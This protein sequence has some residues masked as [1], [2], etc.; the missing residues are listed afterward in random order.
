[1]TKPL[2]TPRRDSPLP[3][4]YCSNLQLLEDKK[5]KRQS[6]SHSQGYRKTNK[7][8]KVT[9]A[10]KN[11][12]KVFKKHVSAQKCLFLVVSLVM[13][14]WSGQFGTAVAGVRWPGVEYPF[15]LISALWN[16]SAQRPDPWAWLQV[17]VLFPLWPP[18]ALK[19]SKSLR[20]YF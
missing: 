15:C 19:K 6:E 20:T 18:Q 17:R 9:L 10:R 8:V 12:T 3:S 7:F 1:M 11:C 2:L 13:E 5:K 16:K 14:G 4:H